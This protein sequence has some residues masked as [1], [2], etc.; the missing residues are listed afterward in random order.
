VSD[1]P[2]DI[3]VAAAE[4]A[5]WLEW[6]RCGLGASDV[7]GVLGLSPWASP[8]SVWADKVGLTDPVDETEAMEFGTLAEPM[9]ARYFT[10]RTGLWVS[11]QQSRLVNVVHDWMRCTLD[12]RVYADR[13][14]PGEYLGNVEFKTTSEPPWDE[15]PVQY[16][17][18][19]T[20]QMIVTG[21]TYCWFGVLHIAYG[22]P[23]FRVY[24]F[25][26]DAEDAATVIDRC[27]TFWHEHVVAGVAPPVDG[28]D[29]TTTALAHAWTPQDSTVEADATTLEYLAAYHILKADLDALELSVEEC[30]NAIR[31]ALTESSTLTHG[32]DFKGR[33]VVLATWKPQTSTRVDPKAL[34]AAHP[35]AITRFEQ[36]T[37][38]RVLRITP[39]KET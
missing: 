31:A 32:L 15:V 21:T 24:E 18:Q 1:A 16:Q 7:A 3:D 22:R 12:G 30:R 8:W 17:C 4:R 36:T 2:S 26:L 35:R 27:T 37:T 11:G 33:P 23:A 6:R 29:A 28:W 34:R 39:S 10:R 20:W 9:L 25:T 19:A 13:D 14:G 38:S 5:E